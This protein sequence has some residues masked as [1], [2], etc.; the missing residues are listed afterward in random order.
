M[1]KYSLIGLWLVSLLCSSCNQD[2][3]TPIPALLMELE[4]TWQ[5]EYGYLD[6][7]E[8]EDWSKASMI[9]SILSDSS[10]SV[11]VVNQPSNRL[12][13]WPSESILTVKKPIEFELFVRNDGII[14]NMFVKDSLK[15]SMHPPREWSYD[16]ECPEDENLLV[17]SEGGA[18]QFL[19]R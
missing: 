10:I 12:N 8:F 2:D 13:I 14:T 4:G 1:S 15:I 6:S 18:W 3:E 17:C 5:F 9:I 16:E 7:N 11:E 19:L